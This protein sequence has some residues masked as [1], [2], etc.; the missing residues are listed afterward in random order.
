MK[1]PELKRDYLFARDWPNRVAYAKYCAWVLQRY[2]PIQELTVQSTMGNSDLVMASVPEILSR[3]QISRLNMRPLHETLCLFY[4]WAGTGYLP[5]SRVKELL[6]ELDT[7][8]DAIQPAFNWM[9]ENNRMDK[10][11]GVG[12]PLAL[13][14]PVNARDIL[15]FM[16]DIE[17]GQ[18][19]TLADIRQHLEDKLVPNAEKIEIKKAVSKYLEAR[20]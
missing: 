6:D 11:T 4:N 9:V 1:R 20:L 19:E 12:A 18:P 5:P 7:L 10:V 8:I 16:Q 14:A 2:A 15:R 17:E 3:S 13:I